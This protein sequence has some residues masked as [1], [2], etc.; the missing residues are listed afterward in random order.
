[1]V[2]T[3]FSAVVSQ[4]ADADGDGKSNYAEYLAGTDPKNASSKLFV[5]GISPA[6]NGLTLN[7][8]SISGKSYSV[9]R[10]ANLSTWTT[11]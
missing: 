4:T 5:R 1:M 10:S 6:G 3:T 2:A 11:L 8:D 9:E 7:W